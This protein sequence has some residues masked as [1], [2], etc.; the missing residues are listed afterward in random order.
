LHA[1]M[2][3]GGNKKGKKEIEPLHAGMPFGGNK[4]GKKEKRRKQWRHSYQLIVNSVQGF[5]I[6]V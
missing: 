1:G 2:P 6:R 5:R 4:K 3:F